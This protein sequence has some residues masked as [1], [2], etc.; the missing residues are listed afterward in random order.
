MEAATLGG[1]PR[2]VERSTAIGYAVVVLDVLAAAAIAGAIAA[3]VV[4][5]ERDGRWLAA[6]LS[7]IG[8]LALALGFVQVGRDL[9]R[10]RLG[11]W[12]AAIAVNALVAVAGVVGLVLI[13]LGAGPTDEAAAAWFVV[14]VATVALTSFAVVSLAVRTTRDRL[15]PPEAG[16]YTDP[17][18]GHFRWWDGAQWTSHT[19]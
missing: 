9:Q 5:G 15:R 1:V 2:P 14:L 12:K 8:A 7:T 17:T 6:T 4:F 18:T 10:R 3:I 19:V 11:A 13:L 16:W